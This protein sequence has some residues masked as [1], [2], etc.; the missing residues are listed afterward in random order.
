MPPI[1]ALRAAGV[2]MAL[3]TDC[4]PGTSP[5]TSPAAGHEHGRDPVPDDRGRMRWRGVTRRGGARRSGAASPTLGRSRPARPVTSPSGTIERPGRAGLP[6]RLQP[7]A[8]PRIRRHDHM[9]AV[10]LRPG[11][12]PYV[13]MAGHLSRGR[14]AAGSSTLRAGPWS[15]ASAEAVGPDRGQAASPPMGSTPAS[16]S[17]RPVSGS[18]LEDLAALQRN[19]VLSHAAGR[20]RTDRPNRSHG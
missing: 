17:W 10:T 18:G 12:V 14:R 15:K 4:N 8:V 11:D 2:P 1:E 19:I 20:G 6:H 16:G 9:D 13:G 5:M 7:P 3:A